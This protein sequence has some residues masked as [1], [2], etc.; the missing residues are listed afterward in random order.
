MTL[1]TFVFIHIISFWQ[2]KKFLSDYKDIAFAKFLSQM[3]SSADEFSKIETRLLLLRDG[4][5]VTLHTFMFFRINY[6]ETVPFHKISTT[7]N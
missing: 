3:F 4:L 7:G 6:A 5:L 2:G 1:N